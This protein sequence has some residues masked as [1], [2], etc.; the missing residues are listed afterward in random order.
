MLRGRWLRFPSGLSCPAV[1]ILHDQASILRLDSKAVI[2][3]L[4]VLSW[5]AKALEVCSVRVHAI[6]R[7]FDL[8]GI[9]NRVNGLLFNNSAIPVLLWHW[10]IG[11]T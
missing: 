1:G 11:I 3:E 8:S 10:A 6:Q 9:E 2:A 7:A 5:Y 4:H